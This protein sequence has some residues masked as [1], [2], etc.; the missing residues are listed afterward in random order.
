[1]PCFLETVEHVILKAQVLMYSGTTLRPLADVTCLP[2]GVVD[3]CMQDRRKDT[4][5]G[6]LGD[7]GGPRTSA[8]DPPSENF[9]SKCMSHQTFTHVLQSKNRNTSIFASFLRTLQKLYKLLQKTA[10][11]LI[12]F[13]RNTAG[14]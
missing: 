14:T 1:M 13:V 6:T 12:F 5:R 11:F 7:A 8:P 4:E 10:S 2:E 3:S 9:T